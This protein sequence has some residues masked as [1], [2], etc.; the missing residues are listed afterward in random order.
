ML[1]TM[2]TCLLAGLVFT[3][4]AA[5]HVGLHCTHYAKTVNPTDQ[6]CYQNQNLGTGG[7]WSTPSTAVRDGNTMVLQGTRL[8][9]L[10]YS[11]GYQ[12]TECFFT[13]AASIPG[14]QGWYARATCTFSGAAVT[15]H[16][17]T[18]WHHPT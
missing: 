14:S 12:Y 9:C 13:S 15:G 2:F 4:L 16:C 6:N 1:V 3:G 8:L 11:S 18:V 5:A 7:V 17:R 10:G